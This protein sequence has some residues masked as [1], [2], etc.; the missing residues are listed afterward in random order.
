MARVK[1]TGY[2]KA[3]KKFGRNVYKATGLVNPMKKGKLSTA[4][5]IK[6][7]AL[8]KKSLNTEKKIYDIPMN[9]TSYVVG[10]VYA[11]DTA[12][13]WVSGHYIADV[14]PIPAQGVTY[15]T[16]NGDSIKLSGIYGKI[17]FYQQGSCVSMVKGVIEFVKVLGT[18]ITS[19]AF[20]SAYLQPNDFIK[21]QASKDIYDLNAS[22]DVDSF[23]NFRVIRRI[24]FNLK[25]DATS[26]D[27]VITNKTLSLK[28]NH[29]VKFDKNTTTVSNGQ[30][31]MV[32]RVDSGNS[33]N[34]TI[35][36]NPQSL[37]IVTSFSGLRFSYYM[38]QYFIDN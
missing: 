18:P 25:A 11:Q 26:S 27:N 14:T 36:G 33:G 19:T 3:L 20:M 34:T 31:F 24:P 9:N 22:R 1:K 38:R 10:Q 6:D 2:K 15:Q 30:I 35:T 32:I 7:V 16:R 13:N 4:R 37:P 28:T 12:T 29:H 17:Q 23:K 21:A 5:L 8:I